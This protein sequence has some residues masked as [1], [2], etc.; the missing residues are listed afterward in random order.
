MNDHIKIGD[1]ITLDIR[2]LGINGEGI[3]YHNKMAVFVDYA[4]PR[5]RIEAEIKAVFHNRAVADIKK[6]I[7]R[8]P[9]RQVPF[10]PVYDRCG[11]CQTQHF[12][13]IKTLIQKRE[14]LIQSFERYTY[15]KLDYRNIKATLGAAHPTHYRNKASLP[16]QMVDGR[17]RFGMYAANS[18]TFVEID[19]CPVQYKEVNEILT[20]IIQLMDKLSIN[21][22]DYKHKTGF[23]KSVVVRH[24][25]ETNE[26]QVSFIMVRRS[27][28]LDQL[29]DALINQ[30]PSVKS[31]FE[32]LKPD[33]KKATYTPR[34]MKLVY[35]EKTIKEVLNGH[36]FHLKPDAFFQLNSAQAHTF[37]TEMAR[38]A[39]LKP[40]ENAVDAYAG[41]APVSHYIAK[42][43]GN[44]FA[45][46][47]DPASVES[48]KMSLE[49]NGITNVHVIQG[50]FKKA[51]GNLKRYQIDVMLFDPPRTGLG[52]ETIRAIQKIKPK[53]IV[54]GSCN[55]ST[56]AKDIH[57]LLV[58]Y[59]HIETV[60]IDMFPYTS[61][62]ESVT[63]LHKK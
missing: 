10:C 39:N 46:E 59:D 55:P 61:L 45:I 27:K 38:L 60:P 50:D 62:V 1:I 19:D 63:L 2:R 37:Y 31:V 43:A 51:L 47:I 58:D 23:V 11:G 9:D 41:V 36:V 28:Y 56:L 49:T 20:T 32:A 52:L 16:V 33:D 30:H 5:E 54:Y 17:N 57:E 42:D 24:S 40:H 8:N 25:Q 35:G 53:R 44:V 22:Y 7:S 34:Q 26:S 4:L 6:I 13:Y 3:G 29:I 12:D 48:A 21:A 14:I 15:P 18:N